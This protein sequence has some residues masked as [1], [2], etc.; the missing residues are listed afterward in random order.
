ML[1]KITEYRNYRKNLRTV[2][3]ELCTAAA[4]LLPLINKT[5]ANSSRLLE[6][7]NYL[8]ELSADDIRKILIDAQVETQSSKNA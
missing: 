1:R 8:S 3:S 7:V 6:I 2:K 5:S 4:T